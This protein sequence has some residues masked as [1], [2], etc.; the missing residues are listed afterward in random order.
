MTCAKILCTIAVIG[1]VVFILLH[2]ILDAGIFPRSSSAC[3]M[4]SNISKTSAKRA[5][6]QQGVEHENTDFLSLTD[7][8]QQSDEGKP[9]QKAPNE[10]VFQESF[11]W[12]VS[13]EDDDEVKSKFDK[14]K[15]ST[16]KAIHAANI[17]VVN[18]E[19]LSETPTYSRTQGL[20]NP[21][22]KIYHGCH[23]GSSSDVKFGN[24]GCTWFGGTDAYYNTRSQETRCDC[25]SDDCSTCTK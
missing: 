6:V 16:T 3:G 11:E 22:L 14:L 4:R 2:G 9:P 20:S 18:S 25:L 10:E 23:N 15:P 19:T 8:W 24:G 17:K 12:N 7:T 1:I 13:N 5:D 21:M